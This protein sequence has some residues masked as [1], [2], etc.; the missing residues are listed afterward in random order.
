MLPVFRGIKGAPITGWLDSDRLVF[1]YFW[2][3]GTED[4]V[5]E[6]LRTKYDPHT[7]PVLLTTSADDGSIQLLG[8]DNADDEPGLLEAARGWPLTDDERA[9]VE[10]ATAAAL[11]DRHDEDR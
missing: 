2:P 10:V 1:A 7:M 11:D 3:P 8:W 4:V 9:W 5:R 6:F